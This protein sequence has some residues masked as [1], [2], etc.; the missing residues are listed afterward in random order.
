MAS[1]RLDENIFRV[2]FDRLTPRA[3]N[4]LH[5]MGELGKSPYCCGDV[6]DTLNLKF[7]ILGPVPA[8]LIKKNMVFS[9]S[10]GDMAFTVP[11]FDVFMCRAIPDSMSEADC[12]RTASL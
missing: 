2:R 3:K 11:L 12:R 8:S 9:Q 5:N 6:A 7:N 4:Y 1:N 10:H